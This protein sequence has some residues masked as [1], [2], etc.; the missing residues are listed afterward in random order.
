MINLQWVLPL[1][2]LFFVPFSAFAGISLDATR[3]VFPE[4]NSQQGI[5]V[6]VTST[7]SS[8]SPYLVKARVVTAPDAESTDTPF[9][10]SPSLFRLE[11]GTTNQLRIM[12]RRGGLPQDRESVYYLQVIAQAAGKHNEPDK[13]L[14]P[15]GAMILSSGTLVKLFYRPAG[16]SVS[17]QKAMADLQFSRRG[18]QLY[19]YNPSPYFITLSSL[20]AGGQS[21]PISAAK[22]NSMLAPFSGQTYAVSPPAGQVTWKAINDYGGTEVFRGE[23]H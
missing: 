4:S 1:I 6:G 5:G 2:F 22:Q 15:G 10:V 20:N 9:V 17:P 18:Q 3:L 14:A 21:V 7:T 11:P 19:V 12:L 16:L 13:P 8:S 23:L